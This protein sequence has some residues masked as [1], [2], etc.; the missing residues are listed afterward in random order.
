MY[1][2][3]AVSL[4]V[5]V[6]GAVAVPPAKAAPLSGV[7]AVIVSADGDHV[8][9]A[10]EFADT[11]VVFR[12]DAA[13][14][15][16]AALQTVESRDDG[17]RLDAVDGVALSPDGR[18]LYVVAFG[19]SAL[20][21]FAVDP[22]SGLLSFVEAQVDDLD[23]AD[24]LRNTHGVVVSPD[25]AHV[26]AGGFGE[27]ALAV[28]ARDAETGAL[29]FVEAPRAD[30]LAG[31]LQLDVSS[32]GAHLYAT[33]TSDDAVTVFARN[34]A[35]GVLAFRQ[36]LRNGDGGASGLRGARTVRVS[37]DGAHVYVGSGGYPGAL[38]DHAI[39][40]FRRDAGTGLLT[41]VDARFDDVEG[42]EGLGGVYDL[43]LAADGTSLYAASFG[44]NAVAVFDRD[45]AD[46]RLAFRQVQY[47]AG[48]R[49]GAA[50]AVAV[51]PDDR[52]VYV[53]AFGEGGVQ[54]F[55]RDTADGSL[56]AGSFI[57]SGADGCPW[58]PPTGCR[59]AARPKL[60]V[61]R[62]GP[63]PRLYFAWRRGDATTLEDIGEP[64]S[65]LPRYGLC[66]WTRSGDVATLLVSGVTSASG[67]WRPSRD[68]VTY[69]ATERG[70]NA[71][72]TLTLH[73]G[74]DG[75][76]ALRAT[77]AGVLTTQDIEGPL[78]VVVQHDDGVCWEATFPVVRGGGR[79]RFN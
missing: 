48:V 43:V 10:S 77:M 25:G 6:F 19:A 11:V 46:G 50:H 57:G 58:E 13:T 3:A 1:R 14:G 42:V 53:G 69:V 60:V 56:S 29:T 74:A 33:G 22:V 76:A 24:G 28:F 78:S 20:N 41:F 47:D 27:G 68:G 5:L 36:V 39:A 21:V 17:P 51:S 67:S 38:A 63:R 16:L 55:V 70:A 66:A 37:P 54:G 23:G 31:V 18:H 44:D 61:R 72:R 30:G 71:L 75:A 45:A 26:Y 62:G 32:D 2:A 73:A 59:Q 9:V 12:R 35:S 7:R 49:L 64:A 15:A 34:A 8:Y 4:V 79:P 40:A 65:G 52:H